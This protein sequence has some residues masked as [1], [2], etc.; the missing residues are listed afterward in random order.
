MFGRRLGADAIIGS[1]TRHISEP[2]I[3]K[4]AVDD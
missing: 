2:K 4:I 1:T 3:P